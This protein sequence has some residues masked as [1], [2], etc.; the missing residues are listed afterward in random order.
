MNDY[1]SDQPV[2]EPLGGTQLGAVAFTGVAAASYFSFTYL[3]FNLARIAFGLIFIEA[4]VFNLST[5]GR[6]GDVGFFLWAVFHAHRALLN[7]TRLLYSRP[8]L[9]E[10]GPFRAG[11]PSEE[12]AL[13][14]RRSW[15][16]A[17]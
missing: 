14:A 1:C 16:S 4:L 10:H 2:A 6:A 3:L 13:R 12:S 8:G 5:S 7:P 17:P 9:L 15:R 11:P